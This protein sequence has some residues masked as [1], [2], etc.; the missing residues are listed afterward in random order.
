LLDVFSSHHHSLLY[1]LTPLNLKVQQ[2]QV[3]EA[4]PKDDEPKT[5]IN[6]PWLGGHD[7]LS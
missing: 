7:Q 2:L 6:S 4:L 1:V 5:A 3:E